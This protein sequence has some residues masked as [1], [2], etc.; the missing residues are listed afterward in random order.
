ME[1]TLL[2]GRKIFKKFDYIVIGELKKA[3]LPIVDKVR[4]GKYESGNCIEYATRG[5]VLLPKSK[6]VLGSIQIVSATLLS[7][8]GHAY[9]PEAGEFHAWIEY[10]DMIID[11]ALPEMIKIGLTQRDS[12]GYFLEGRQPVI[13]AGHP[14]EWIS[15]VKEDSMESFIVK[16]TG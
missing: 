2:Y 10:E 8:Y 7:S 1:M 14:P 11:F 15:Y 4:Q 13:L 3:V 5:S 9:R 16:R 12:V 6:I